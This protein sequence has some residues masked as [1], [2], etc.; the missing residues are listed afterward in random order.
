[1]QINKGEKCFTF[2]WWWLGSAEALDFPGE[3]VYG[4]EHDRALRYR[5]E[6]RSL[7]D[8]GYVYCALHLAFS[9]SLHT[10]YQL[11]SV[12]LLY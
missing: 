6:S 1:M 4:I 9:T 11:Q 10:R 7:Y 8:V 2:T 12:N 3:N 5:M